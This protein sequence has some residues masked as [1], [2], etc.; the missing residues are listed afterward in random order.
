MFLY[1]LIVAGCEV[2]HVLFVKLSWLPCL[3]VCRHS[4]GITF[5]MFNLFLIICRNK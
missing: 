3:S 2:G 4:C 1:T 5:Y